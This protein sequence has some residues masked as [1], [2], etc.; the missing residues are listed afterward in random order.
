MT[1][2]RVTLRLEVENLHCEGCAETLREA[3]GNRPG[4][5][6]ATVDVERQCL[7]VELDPEVIGGEELRDVL[8][9]AGFPAGGIERIEAGGEPA[10]PSPARHAGPYG[11]L[12]LALL[13][14]GAAGYAGYE[15]YPR[16]DLPSAQGATLLLLAAG[17][18]IASFFSPCAFGLLVTLLA[19][20]TEDGESRPGLARLLRFAA[21]MSLGASLFV[22]AVGGVIALGGSGLVAGVTF[23]SP[24]GRALRLAVGALLLLLGL[25]QLELLP[26]PLHRVEEWVKPLQRLSARQRRQR[27]FWGYVLFGFGYL[28][29]GFG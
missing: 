10:E 17:A 28:L 12:A 16:F 15:L 2:E 25:V 13:L 8:R 7:R 22:L 21:G 26:N 29:A 1:G 20:R 14:V 24:A 6:L 18:G 4:L 5:E 3:L 27:P 11:L 23:T 9:T 19:R